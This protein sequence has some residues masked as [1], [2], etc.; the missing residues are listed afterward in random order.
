MYVMLC[1]Y[2]TTVCVLI[3]C[4]YVECLYSCICMHVFMHDVYAW[5]G[6]YVYAC[7]GLFHVCVS[8]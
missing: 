3:T 1:N 2:V 6:V 4:L 7:V 5:M 8:I